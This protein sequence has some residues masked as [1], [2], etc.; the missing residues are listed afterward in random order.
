[1]RNNRLH[2][3]FDNYWPQLLLI[4]IVFAGWW[5][6][7]F[8]QT[9]FKFDA[10]YNHL[11]WR[12][13]IVDNLRHGHL[14]LWN[15]YHHLGT[16]IHADPQS[17]AWYPV[18]WLFAL[19]GTYDLYSYGAE[20]ML[21]IVIAGLGMQYLMKN[22]GMSKTVQLMISVVYV[23]SGFFASNSMFLTWVISAAWIPFIFGQYIKIIE[24]PSLK[25]SL[26]LAFFIFMLLTGGYPAFTIV[27]A[28][29]LVVITLIMIFKERQK[30]KK[31]LFFLT[32]SVVA[33]A[34]LATVLLVSVAVVIP[35][36]TRGEPLP[37]TKAVIPPFLPKHFLSLILPYS[38]VELEYDQTVLFDGSN[39][40]TGILSLI[41]LVS[42]IL[43][44]KKSG[45]FFKRM[46]LASV[47]FFLLSFGDGY[48][49][50]YGAYHYLPGF[51]Y[52]R[53]PTMFRYF[54]ML[55][56]LAG[57]AKV[58]EDLLLKIEFIK[59]KYSFL[60]IFTSVFIFLIISILKTTIF[61]RYFSESFY[62]FVTGFS[63]WDK[64]FLQSS[65]QLIILLII[66][67]STKYIRSNKIK[68][69]AL[70]LILFIDLIVAFNIYLPY[71][72]TSYKADVAESN[73]V[74]HNNIYDFS[75]ENNSNIYQNS[76]YP[77]SV[78]L[79]SHFLFIYQKRIAD[80]GNSFKLKAFKRL[81]KE[82]R[83]TYKQL[84]NNP[85]FY[86][87]K[88]VYSD[89]LLLNS[90]KILPQTSFCSEY[91]SEGN[92]KLKGK[93]FIKLD[94]FQYNS[95]KIYAKT[96]DN[97]LLVFLQNKYPGWKASV[98]GKSVKIMSVNKIFMGIKIPKG[99]HY[100]DFR[101]EPNAI[102]KGFYISVTS[103]FVLIFYLITVLYRNVF[104]RH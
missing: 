6:I 23:F 10:I 54:A 37:W 89:S 66:L 8:F 64:V 31:S 72:I 13:L 100:V 1:L 99:K 43:Q 11:P 34:L 70:S 21:H 40:Y 2:I 103:F 88:K 39:V 18:V 12:F 65:F 3:V 96:S 71:T 83:K 75:L 47:I 17:G 68:P 9:T 49:F 57:T 97:G 86:F 56:M 63:F 50:Y 51:K 16:P 38:F 94:R 24:Q 36:M 28:Y 35:Y 73:N 32:V 41:F 33:A 92:H 25:N 58:A 76:T 91:L 69:I 80:K 52:F 46:I 95:I 27:T 79:F 98:D 26:L 93:T 4:L 42:G 55:A 29:S 90:N 44:W 82:E 84:I 53:F 48:G 85:L 74:L 60:I 78:Y 22:L 15:Y 59:I 7:A 14:P 81:K 62:D 30:I 67:L 5:Q 61:H 101:F 104:K 87:S 20:F 19:F 77:D 45:R 102:I